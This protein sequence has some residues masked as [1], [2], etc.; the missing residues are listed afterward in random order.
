MAVGMRGNVLLVTPPG[1]GA[2]FSHRIALRQNCYIVPFSRALCVS[3]ETWPCRD[4]SYLDGIKARLE[5]KTKNVL[6]GR[7]GM[8]LTGTGRVSGTAPTTLKGDVA[9]SRIY[10]PGL[11]TF[12]S[13]DLVCL[14]H[15]SE[16]A[17][18]HYLKPL[19]ALLSTPLSRLRY[20][21]PPSFRTT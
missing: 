9:R 12:A 16:E 8:G 1:I 6:M 15:L 17:G 7:C 11:L 3:P 2:V 21:E 18:C 14:P 19:P 5:G 13:S 4:A 20:L 10:V